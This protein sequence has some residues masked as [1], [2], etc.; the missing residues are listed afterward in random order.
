MAHK[1]PESLSEHLDTIRYGSHCQDQHRPAM[2]QLNIW[3]GWRLTEGRGVMPL[4]HVYV[5]VHQWNTG[6]AACDLIKR[7]T[8]GLC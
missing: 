5:P 1:W 2:I 4:I 6:N 3:D 8:E 7:F